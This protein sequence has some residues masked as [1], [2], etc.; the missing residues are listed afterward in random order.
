MKTKTIFIISIAA[1]IAATAVVSY[2]IFGIDDYD[3]RLEGKW[4][5]D[6]KVT[7]D[8]IIKNNVLPDKISDESKDK[9]CNIFGRL[10]LLVK[11][12]KVTS[13]MDDWTE[14][15]SYKIVERGEKFVIIR[16]F[17]KTLNKEVQYRIDFVENGCW[18]ESPLLF[19]NVFKKPLRE[20]FD[21]IK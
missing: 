1:V 15:E 10:E 3:Q 13:S 2:L 5:S 21:K 19:K 20:K 7:V 8:W 9:F 14:T 11:R 18:V 17:N 4:K 6:K 12:N 16:S